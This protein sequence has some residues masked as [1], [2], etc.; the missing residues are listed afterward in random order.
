MILSPGR[1]RSR[2][3]ECSLSPLPDDAQAQGCRRSAAGEVQ[4]ASPSVAGLAARSGTVANTGSTPLCRAAMSATTGSDCSL[5]RE[6]L[7]VRV[8]WRR[9]RGGFAVI[10]LPRFRTESRDQ[11]SRGWACPSRDTRPAIRPLPKWRGEPPSPSGPCVY[12]VSPSAPANAAL[13][14][15]PSRVEP[16]PGRDRRLATNSRLKESREEKNEEA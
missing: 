2:R 13:L 5:G 10:P 1:G 15:N 6:S 7:C 9:E 11:E 8:V 12:R 4:C 16:S 3:W 14:D